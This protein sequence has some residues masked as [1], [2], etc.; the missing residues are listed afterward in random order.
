MV[1]VVPESQDQEWKD[2]DEE[3]GALQSTMEAPS[4]GA[5]RT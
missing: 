5:P 4:P 2:R 1:L 3:E